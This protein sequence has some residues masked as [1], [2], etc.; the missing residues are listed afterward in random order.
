[1]VLAVV[2]AMSNYKVIGF[3]CSSSLGYQ[4]WAVMVDMGPAQVVPVPFKS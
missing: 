1:M 3:T 2:M 4:P